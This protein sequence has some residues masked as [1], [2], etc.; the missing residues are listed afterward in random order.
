METFTI[1]SLL[2]ITSCTS[3]LLSNVLVPSLVGCLVGFAVYIASFQWGEWGN[4]RKYSKLGVLIIEMLQE[5]V[6]TG[7]EIMSQAES[8]INDPSILRPQPKDLDI[9]E[10]LPT[11]SWSGPQTIPDEVLL[12]ISET[13]RGKIGDEL[14]T[15][16]CRIHCKNYFDHMCTNYGKAAA[17]AYDILSAEDSTKWKRCFS[18]M[19]EAPTGTYLRDAQRVY[20][21]LNSV[22]K[23]LASNSKRWFPR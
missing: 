3:Y 19:L 7:I 5:E 13:F 8:V 4:R 15:T 10:L 11:R 1:H 17:I 23:Q 21:M 9:F 20:D 16:E 2:Q 18:G 6:R 22:K 14:P 12:R